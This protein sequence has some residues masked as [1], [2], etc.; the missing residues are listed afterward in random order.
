MKDSTYSSLNANR[1]ITTAFRWRRTCNCAVIPSSSVTMA[2]S[3]MMFDTE[4]TVHHIDCQLLVTALFK[5]PGRPTRSRHRPSL[6]SHG[7]G[8]WHSNAATNIEHTSHKDT[9]INTPKLILRCLAEGVRW[10]TNAMIASFEKPR[11]TISRIIAAYSHFTIISQND[12][13]ICKIQMYLPSNS[14]RSHRCLTSR[15]A[16]RIH[17]EFAVTLR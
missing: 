16:F 15:L 2:T 6:L 9:S 11:E 13:V 4:T 12:L 10:W 3:V 1:D 8:S 14:L 17:S 5:Y 7:R